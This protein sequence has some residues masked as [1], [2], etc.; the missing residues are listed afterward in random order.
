MDVT[1][2]P[3]IRYYS[4]DS[5]KIHKTNRI[6]ESEERVVSNIVRN[7]KNIAL[8]QFMK[9]INNSIFKVN[10]DIVF[11]S[12]FNELGKYKNM[13]N[14]VSG[15]YFYH[16]NKKLI[17]VGKSVDYW[18]RFGYCYLKKG[19]KVHKNPNLK[20]LIE[21]KPEIV[22]VVFAPMDNKLLK[23]QE[24]LFIQ[25]FIPLFN[26]AE[27]PRFEIQ[28]IQKV[29]AR[30]VN[31]TNREWTYDEMREFLSLKWKREVPFEKLDE[32]LENKNHNLS[33]YCRTVP[34]QKILKPKKKNSVNN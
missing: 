18:N 5:K 29:I 2:F 28:S 25:E 9:K 3:P 12:K 27:N 26:K 8:L 16:V 7:W 1:E 14:K 21:F 10:K 24:T 11:K 19:S 34:K 32:A 17:Y 13:L 31:Q 15:L 6:I 22:G 23:E 30:I 20:K 33:R 4:P